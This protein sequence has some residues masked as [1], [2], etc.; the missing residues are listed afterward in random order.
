MIQ[1]KDWGKEVRAYFPLL[2]VITLAKASPFRSMAYSTVSFA[3]IEEVC[4]QSH[5]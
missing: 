2:F 5:K 4:G 3:P 1:G